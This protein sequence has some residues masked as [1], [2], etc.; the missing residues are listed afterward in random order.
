M[1]E[2]AEAALTDPAL[3]PNPGFHP[4]RLVLTRGALD[5]PARRAFVEKARAAFP[6]AE[7]VKQL[8]R[9]HM[10]AALCAPGRPHAERVARGKRTLVI[11]VIGNAVRRSREKGVA[12]PNYWHF[13]TTGFCWYDCAY[14]YL[15]GSCSSLVSP[16][17]KVFVNLEDVLRQLRRLSRR[18]ERAGAPPASCY[19]GKLQDGLSLDWL[20]GFS[21]ALVPFF[22]REPRLRWVVLTKSA[23]VDHLLGLEHRG[24]SVISWSVNPARLCR[25]YE[26]GAASLAERLRAAGRCARAGYPVRFLIMPL[27]P[28]E[29]WPELYR[30]LVDELLDA[31][32]PERITM[33]G[34]CSFPT[35]RRLAAARGGGCFVE[36]AEAVGPDGRRRYP[37]ALRV[38]MYQVI[39]DAI[40]RRA[41][42]LPVGLCLEEPAVWRAVG[43]N[44]RRA[45]CNCIWDEAD[46]EAGEKESLV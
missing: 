6:D 38:K 42:D 19:L 25:A 11:G 12:C 13:S 18:L 15:A 4:E 41:P 27:L 23:C 44:P 45:R 35:A 1:L 2:L 7:V 28:V 29:G 46:G 20:T 21:K 8:D 26:P 40:R 22:A 39:L 30:R 5:T 43:L 31:A 16:T 10:D 3:G 14:C 34:I 17:V 32:A 37:P 33:G 9:S 24:R 36:A